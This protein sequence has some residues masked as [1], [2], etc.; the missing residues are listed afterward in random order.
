MAK[1]LTL[2]IGIPAYNEEINIKNLIKSIL[3]QKA[4][5][6]SLEEIIVISD[7]STDKTCEEVQSIK[8]PKINLIVGK[9]RLGKRTRLNTLFKDF[10]GDVIILLDADI[11]LENEHVLEKHAEK[12]IQSPKTMLVSS[13]SFPSKPSGFI[14]SAIYSSMIV[15]LHTREKIKAGNNIYGCTGACLGLRAEF[16]KNLTIPEIT[17]DDDYIY[18][19]CISRGYLFG[20]AKDSKVSYQLPKTIKDYLRQAFRSTP[21]ATK[22]DFGALHQKQ[23]LIEFSRPKRVVLEGLV[24]ALKTNPIGTIYISLVKLLCLP[25]YSFFSKNYKLEWFSTKTTRI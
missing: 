14:E 8:N 7:G 3:M 6:F 4:S 21:Q 17:A 18:L 13:N 10:R 12:F 19:E 20:Y 25:F 24:L 22:N 9:K 16:A 23:L 15:Y 5:N 11:T 2:T 1:K